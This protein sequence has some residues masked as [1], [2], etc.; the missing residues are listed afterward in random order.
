M[1]DGKKRKFERFGKYLIL[2]HL[3]DGG[4]A[5]IC[6]AR[7]LGEQ[8]DKLVAIK[9]VQQQFSKDPSFVQM[10]ED[11][12]KVTFGLQHPNIAQMYDYGMVKGQLY[13]AMELVDGANLKQYLDRLKEKNFVFPVEISTYIISQVCQ[14]LH[15]SHTFT[16]KMTGKKLNIIHRDISPHNIMLTYDGAVKVID[17]GIAKA[18]SNSEATQAGTIKGKLSYL[19]PE[20]LDGLELDPRYDEFA[21]GI[22]LW[23]MLCSRKL[24][25]ASNDLAV[26]KQIQACKIPAPSSINPNVPK[27]LDDIVQKALAKDRN[28]RFEDMDKFNRALVKFL[29]S[30]YPDFNATDL[31]YFAKQLFK[32]EISKDKKRFVEYGKIDIKPFIQEME[33]EDN[34]KD[35]GGDAPGSSVKGGKKQKKGGT[36]RFELDMGGKNIDT[37]GLELNTENTS[38]GLKKPGTS[39]KKVKRTASDRRGGGTAQARVKNRRTADS[40]KT[41]VRKVTT[42]KRGAAG[43]ESAGNNNLMYSG[44]AVAVLFAL[45]YAQSDLISDITGVDVSKMM[46]KKSKKSTVVQRKK[47]DSDDDTEVNLDQVKP[48]VGTLSLI[49]YD[50]DMKVLVNGKP[51]DMNGLDAEVPL[52]KKLTLSISKSGYKPFKMENIRLTDEKAFMNITIPDLIKERIGLLSTSHNFTTGSKLVFDMPNG[53]TFE[54]NLPLTNERIPAGK[55]EGVIKNP[56]LGTEKKVKFKIEENKRVYLE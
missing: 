41:G 38:T 50:S 34:Q 24:F 4:M 18:D 1:A 15:Y 32:E 31:G 20:Y 46:G 40:T 47:M 30:N 53:R 22:T 3:V 12:L 45:I 9:M 25:T 29:Y 19:A 55:Y 49:G 51:V 10:F 7:F 42:G 37:G 16:D 35:S 11:E 33:N 5:K 2:D 14:A 39:T 26:L 43:K 56:L 44:V 52:F 23:E 8:A 21:V 17:F 36:Q 54:K 27:E 28:Q 48:E 13:T 6:R